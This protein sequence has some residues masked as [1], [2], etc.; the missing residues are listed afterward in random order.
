ME[1][2]PACA[3]PIAILI[4]A[5]LI[6]HLAHYDSGFTTMIGHPVQHAGRRAH[7]ISAIKLDPAAAPP[8]AIAALPLSTAYLF[9]VI[10]SGHAKGLKFEV[11]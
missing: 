4:D 11:A 6:F 2:T 7:R 3:A 5:N 1:R 8:I 10:G 9:S